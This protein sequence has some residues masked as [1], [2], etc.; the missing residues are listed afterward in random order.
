MNSSTKVTLMDK[1]SSV[2]QR[3][4]KARDHQYIEGIVPPLKSISEVYILIMNNFLG[5]TDINEH[6]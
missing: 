1:S 6:T 4:E 2:Y 3:G 5:P